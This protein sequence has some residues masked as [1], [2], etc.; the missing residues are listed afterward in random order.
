MR[1]RSLASMVLPGVLVVALAACPAEP[2]PAAAPVTVSLPPA[3]VGTAPVPVVLAPPAPEPPPELPGVDTRALDG[4]EHAEW[5]ALVRELMA[6]CP[7]V[8]VPVGQC[9]EEHRDCRACAPAATWVAHAVHEGM[10]REQVRARYLSRFDPSGVKTLPLD[11]S[12]S[13]GAADA[14]VTVVEFVDLECPHCREGSRQLDAVLDAH[15]GKVRIVYKSFPLSG[16]PHAEAAARAAVAAGLQGKFWP[17]EHLLL[18]GQEHLEPRDV[19][20]YARSLKLDMARWRT[21]MASPAVAQRVADDRKLGDDLKILGTP[22]FYV[23]G[24]ELGEDDLLEERVRQE[25]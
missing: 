22:A 1:L 6:P 16:H 13:K 17:M 5:A 23:D 21:D 8:A 4:R 24:R 2:P 9:V 10:A 18:E 14:P 7:S 15:P 3:P 20:G 19:E 25:L 12:P 11:G